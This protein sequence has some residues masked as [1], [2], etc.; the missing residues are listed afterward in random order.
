MTAIRSERK[1]GTFDVFSERTGDLIGMT[2]ISSSGDAR[3]FISNPR[4]LTLSELE[5]VVD[6]MRQLEFENEM[7][8]KTV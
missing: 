2:Y 4:A 3:L 6:L 5:E 7:I 8:R 1:A